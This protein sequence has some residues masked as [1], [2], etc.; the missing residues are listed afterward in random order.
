MGKIRGASIGF[1]VYLTAITNIRLSKIR[2]KFAMFHTVLLPA[3]LKRISEGTFF[4][5]RVV[6]ERRDGNA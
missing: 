4:V 3:I 6:D 5:G 2:G 1:T